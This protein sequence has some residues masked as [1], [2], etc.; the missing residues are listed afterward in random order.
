[1][2]DWAYVERRSVTDPKGRS[3]TVAVMDMLGQHGDP[4]IPSQ[5]AEMQYA[6]GRYFALIYSASGS[7]QWESGHRTLGEATEAFE[8]LLASVIDGSLDPSQPV[9]RADLED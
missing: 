7:I 9:F 3:W 8:R 5:V 2:D 4:A 6:S 1:M